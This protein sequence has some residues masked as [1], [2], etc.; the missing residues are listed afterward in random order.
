MLSLQR[1]QMPR[2]LHQMRFLRDSH[3]AILRLPVYLSRLPQPQTTKLRVEIH[4][5]QDRRRSKKLNYLLDCML[6]LLLIYAALRIDFHVFHVHVTI[7][8]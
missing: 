3:E 8:F 7:I 2:S 1:I 6:R 5:L 4:S